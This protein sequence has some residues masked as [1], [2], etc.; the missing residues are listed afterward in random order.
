MTSSA[1]RD[2]RIDSFRGLMLAEIT[3]VHLNTPIGRMCDE[4]F[5]RVSAAAGF[6]F[7]SGIV[8]GAVYSR[9]AE[10][11][12]A[13]VTQR[14]VAR[15]FYIHAYHVAAFLALLAVAFLEPR[16]GSHFRHVVSPEG[17]GLGGV[18]GSFAVWAY[19]PR[20]F[21][22]LPMYG[23]FVLFM[24][25][26][27]LALRSNR[28][29]SMLLVSLG[30]WVLA[31]LGLGQISENAS[32]FGLFHG[33]FNPFAWQFVFFSGLYFG[34][35][36][37]YR[38]RPVIEVRPALVAL[39]LFICAMG[40]TMRWSLL[41]WPELFDAGG[42]L[43]YKR[44]YGTAFLVNFLAFAYLIYA[45]AQRWPA[46]FTWRPLAF[47]GQHSIQVFS[48][49]IVAVYVASLL[50]GHVTPHGF[51]AFDALG[52][53]LVASLFAVAWCHAKWRANRLGRIGQEAS[54]TSKRMRLPESWSG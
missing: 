30:I 41:P 21:D 2:I 44:D 35:M 20:L 34:H 18:L 54:T 43:A 51:W 11:S 53:V 8:A 48:F 40:F 7:L 13:A 50:I 6:V 23:L 33:G 24:P 10:K 45:L 38:R 25:A 17:E 1:S 49:Q 39:C 9:T 46:A 29:H 42:L 27:L 22:V 47:L 26:A 3:L 32:P 28:G 15:A 36:H 52:A 37:L 14:C 16:A 31:Q 19:Q 12:A 4:F 5:G